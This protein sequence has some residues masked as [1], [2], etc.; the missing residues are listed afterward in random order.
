MHMGIT[1]KELAKK[2]NL[3]A[4]A[5]SMALNNKPGVSSE[6]RKKVKVAAEKYGYDFDR[7]QSKK[8]KTG[9]IEFI[10]YKKS[11][12]VVDDTPFFSKVSEGIQSACAEEGYHLRTRYLYE[13]DFGEK[14]LE[15]IQFSDCAG[16]ILLGTEMVTDD[17][18]PFLSMPIP[19]IVLDSYFETFSCDT[20]I[21]NN[22]Q[23]AYV[24]TRH[25][26]NSCK[27]QPGY[28]K[29]SYTINNFLER[30]N[31]FKKAVRAHGMSCSQ[32]LIHELTPSISGAYADMKELLEK[33]EPLARCYFADN[34]FIAAGV[35][36]ALKEAGKRI[37][38]DVAIVGFDNIP[39]SQV[40]DL[41]TI[42]V[43][44]EYMGYLAANRLFYR[45]QN[46]KAPTVKLA[47]ATALVDRYSC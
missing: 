6:T 35:I 19:V 36:K 39:I 44:K 28:L 22:E 45:I 27:A 4:A 5:V 2:L 29:S 42:N 47:V 14:D 25:L 23:G 30:S 9:S 32:S 38:E 10:I 40:L 7:I 46:P 18:K 41:T 24:A 26:I 13:A 31:G 15:E 12:A 37:P 34:D 16:I 21:I 20:V 1:A 43:P 3:S 17:L 11:G 8:T 33:N